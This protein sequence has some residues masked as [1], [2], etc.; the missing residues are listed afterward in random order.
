LETKA[1]F[2][3]DSRKA[4]FT[5]A[6]VAEEKKGHGGLVLDVR[7]VTL[8]ADYFVIV[9]G[10]T[11]TQ[12]KA[13]VEAIDERLTKLGYEPRGIEG[14][15]EGRWVL[16]DYGDLIVHVLQERERNFYKLEQFWN[17]A[18]IVDRKLWAED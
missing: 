6:N 4:A 17:Q 1:S 9:G 2:T 10:E 15:Q 8:L 16:L 3:I 12:V 13:I 5:A 11:A 7:Q 14:K 18:L